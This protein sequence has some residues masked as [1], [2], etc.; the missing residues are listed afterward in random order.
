MRTI[1]TAAISAA[2]IALAFLF[3]WP[4]P[5]VP[6]DP[7]ARLGALEK[8]VADL[9]AQMRAGPIDISVTLTRSGTSCRSQTLPQATAT[10]TQ[11]VRWH[12]VNVDCNLAG[13]E[14]EIRFVGDNTP[15][16]V[17][18]PR[19]GRFIQAR[20]RGDAGIAQYKYALWAVGAAGDFLLEDPELWIAEF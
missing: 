3:F 6:P 9:R 20:V 15:L 8:E 13:R 10:R 5:P 18:R 19:H 12:I 11:R 16:D 14:I 2:L 1:V 7:G 4:K 17:R